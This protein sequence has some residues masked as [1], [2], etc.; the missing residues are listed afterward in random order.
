MAIQKTKIIAPY[1]EADP[2]NGGRDH[3]NI[4]FKETG[5]SCPTDD[6]TAKNDMLDKILVKYRSAWKKL[7]KL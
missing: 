6:K 1:S 7:A 5:V 3:R 4:Q 2:T